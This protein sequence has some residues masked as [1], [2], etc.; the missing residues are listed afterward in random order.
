MVVKALTPN[1]FHSRDLTTPSGTQT[2]V[3]GGDTTIQERSKGLYFDGESKLSHGCE[4][5][6]LTTTPPGMSDIVHQKIQ[7]KCSLI[8]VRQHDLNSLLVAWLTESFS[9]ME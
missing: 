8:A 1:H 5:Q 3:T 9:I 2:L 4:C 7:V 6:I